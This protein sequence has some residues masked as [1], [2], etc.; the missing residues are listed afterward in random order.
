MHSLLLALEKVEQ[1]ARASKLTRFLA[2]PV[3]YGQAIL[4]RQLI[5]PRSRRPAYRTVPAFFGEPLTVAL[6]AGTD[7]YLT[8]GKT[9]DSEI[10]LAKYFIN[11][12]GPGDQV[13]DIGAHFGYFTLL[14]AHLVGK[15]GQVQSFEAS[16]INYQLLQQNTAHLPQ[17]TSQNQAVSDQ[18]GTLTFYQFPVQ[19]SEYN[20][21]DVA[22]Y[23]H[24]AWFQKYTPEAI[25]V[26]AVTIDSIFSQP[27]FEPKMIKIDVEGGELQVIKGGEHTLQEQS[28]AVIMEYLAP[29]R[30]NQVHQQASR[31]LAQFRY[32]AHVIT[33]TG[34]LLP[35]PDPDLYLKNLHLDSD[36]LVFLKKGSQ[37]G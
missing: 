26:P 11:S 33:S 14:A 15:T 34:S 12:L 21:R 5:Y 32:E 35:C 22:Q 31:L 10:R 8:G 25:T 24:E 9:H 2:H 18:E 16:I 27:E 28:P 29:S 19:F 23:Q 36:N 7:I 30:H 37:A 1:L 20:S 3:R 17:V 13:L 4:F 6:P